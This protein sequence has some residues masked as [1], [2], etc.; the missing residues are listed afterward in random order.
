MEL[1]NIISQYAVNRA[2]TRGVENF[3]FFYGTILGLSGICVA[4]SS[5]G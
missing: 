3:P 1:G 2:T 4:G 5:T